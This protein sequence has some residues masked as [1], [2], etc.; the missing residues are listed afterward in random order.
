MA[1]APTAHRR[2]SDPCRLGLC[3]LGQ[4]VIRTF[5]DAPQ[6]RTLVVQRRR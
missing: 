6:L 1:P 3:A 4:R 2:R 5:A